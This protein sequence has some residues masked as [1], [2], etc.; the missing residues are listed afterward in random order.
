MTAT[1]QQLEDAEKALGV[2]GIIAG[3][4]SIISIGLNI[5]INLLQNQQGR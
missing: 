3:A 4:V 5:Y 1:S 2:I